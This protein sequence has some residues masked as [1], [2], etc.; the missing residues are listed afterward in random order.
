MKKKSFSL[1]LIAALIAA[2]LLS[3]CGETGTAGGI[4]ITPDTNTIYTTETEQIVMTN[5]VTNGKTDELIDNFDYLFTDIKNDTAAIKAQS[6]DDIVTLYVCEYDGDMRCLWIYD[7]K[8]DTIFRGISPRT[9]YMLS[10]YNDAVVV[11][12][13]D[14]EAFIAPLKSDDPRNWDEFF[15]GENIGTGSYSWSIIIEYKGGVLEKHCGQGNNC[16][17]PRG[18]IELKNKL[19]GYK[20]GKNPLC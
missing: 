1:L 6:L 7:A 16:K 2:L 19:Y 8:R 3:G 14:K 4:E 20:Y 13:S 18:F 12:G 5:T 9:G 10:D 15:P 17:M 11:S